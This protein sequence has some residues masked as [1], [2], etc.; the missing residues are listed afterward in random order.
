M[1]DI[2]NIK[3]SKRT[4]LQNDGFSLVELMIT[5]AVSSVV[6]LGLSSVMTNTL[7]QSA[8]LNDA[9][10]KN[11]I[12]SRLLKS[13]NCKAT[14]NLNTPPPAGSPVVLIDRAGRQIGTPV[15]GTGSQFDGSY[16]IQGL[17]YTK[18]YYMGNMG[19]T[20]QI[21]RRTN[22]GSWDFAK[23]PLAGFN[24]DFTSVKPLLGGGTAQMLCAGQDPIGIVIGIEGT[25]MGDIVKTPG[26]SI[27][28]AAGLK[29]YSCVW[30][31][32]GSVHVNH[33]LYLFDGCRLYCKNLP[34]KGYVTGWPSGCNFYKPDFT[35]YS[36]ANTAAGRA[37][38]LTQGVTCSC[39]R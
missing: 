13:V 8:Y 27:A 6:G 19:I 38:R 29:Q 16:Q 30:S 20:V 34:G 33:P 10:E 31:G 39:I 5:L 3:E 21:A 24:Q 9:V 18:A 12:R 11:E 2:L 4:N 14:V 32:H 15:T 36:N 28:A 25:T 35:S 23:S 1:K 22:S 7:K 37:D 17:Y 26:L